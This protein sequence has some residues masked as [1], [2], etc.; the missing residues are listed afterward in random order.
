MS[1]VFISSTQA[2]PESQTTGGL[3][4]APPWLKVK[5]HFT[6][7]LP[8]IKQE[9]QREDREKDNHSSSSFAAYTC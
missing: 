6:S 8:C 4:P 3:S 9:A 2:R 1:F 5:N 7:L